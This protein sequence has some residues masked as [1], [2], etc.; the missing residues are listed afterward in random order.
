MALRSINTGD[1]NLDS[2][3]VEW[4]K[5]NKD[6]K[7]ENE[8]LEYLDKGQIKVL[9]KLF[10]K[11]LEFGTAGLRGRMGPGYSQMNDLVIVQTGQGLTK[12]LINT[13]LDVAQKGVVVGYDGRYNSKRFA[14]LTAAILIANGIKAYLF[15]KI[16]PT[17]FIPYTILKYKCAAGIMVTA[18]H[19]PKD[20]NGYK[21]YWENGAQIISPHDKQIQSYI[22]NNLVPLESSWDV[23]QIYESS[24]YKD[25]RDDIMQQYY[26]DLQ[27]DVIYPAVNRDSTLKFTYTAM[28]GVGHEYMT[29]AFEAVNLKPFITVEEQKLPDPE[30]PTVKFPNPEEGKSALDLSIK[31]ADKSDSSIILA[32]DPDADRLACATKTESGEWHVF[33]GNELG[34]LLGWWMIHIHQVLHPDVDM[35][36]TYMLAS[37][38]SSKILASMGKKEGFN[39]EETLTGFKWMGN[40][41][42]ELMKEDKEV[43]F[44]YEEAIGFMCGSNV[45]DKDGISA[46][47]RVA[48][49]AAYLDTL[50]LTLSDKLEEIYEE[51]GHHISDN[52]YWICHDPDTIKTI[53][54]RL[55]NYAGRP[56]SYPV[57]ILKGKYTIT[58]IRDLT[59]GYDNSKPDSKAVLPVSKSSQMITFTFKNGLVTT[60][61]TSGTEPKIKYYNELCGSP[62]EDLNKLKSV[63]SEMV[64]AIVAEFLQP[65][66]NGLVAREE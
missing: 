66:V 65:E 64:S 22:L 20:D 58:G 61:R 5:W 49:L 18:S 62:G 17:P 60:L 54:E 42:I 36:K 35:R 43:L 51:Y 40:R 10:F 52:S 46:G 24:Y 50:G 13:I 25:P 2:K 59:T 4:F 14:E 29:A 28:H 56:N 1:G 21:V 63:L 39:F 55:R 8:I 19:N 12:Y 38:V 45:L 37:T 48:E 30:F 41:A 53:F 57:G 27:N 26:E 23:S 44:A 47:V 16:C 33:S 34:A 15:S 9:S 6:P 32:N 3:I 31:L 11:R 7:A